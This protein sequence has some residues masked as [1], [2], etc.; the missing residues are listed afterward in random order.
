MYLFYIFNLAI[1]IKVDGKIK[2]VKIC[3]N[4][5]SIK[6]RPSLHR[7]GLV[8]FVLL[9]YDQQLFKYGHLFY[10]FFDIYDIFQMLTYFHYFDRIENI[11]LN[12]SNSALIFR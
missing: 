12:S 2:Y 7:R 10:S 8:V 9:D 4:E 11:E 5:K 1:S 6:I 3:N